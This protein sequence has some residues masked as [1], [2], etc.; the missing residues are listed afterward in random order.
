M[1]AP[2]FWTSELTLRPRRLRSTP[3]MTPRTECGCQPVSDIICSTVPPVGL[4]SRVISWDCLDAP[5]VRGSGLAFGEGRLRAG[6]AVARVARAAAGFLERGLDRV[7]LVAMS[8]SVVRR[9][10][11]RP[12]Q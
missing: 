2:D 5:S 1:R 7:D 11:W 6:L 9:A 10:R 12:D 3:L 4:C 8:I